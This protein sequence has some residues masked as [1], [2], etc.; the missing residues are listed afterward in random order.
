M[1]QKYSIRS[2]HFPCNLTCIIC[3]HTCYHAK[4]GRSRSHT[5]GINRGP[6]KIG[7]T[8]PPPIGVG[9]LRPRNTPLPTWDDCSWSSS[10]SVRMEIRREM[11]PFKVTEGYRN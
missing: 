1:P 9:R 5:A 11:G 7:S 4:F 2:F 10:T 8:G 3:T 6:I